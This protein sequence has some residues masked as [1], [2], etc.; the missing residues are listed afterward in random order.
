VDES[1]AAALPD[2]WYID[3]RRFCERRE[4]LSAA[5]G[6]AD[7]PRLDDEAIE[8]FDPIDVKVGALMSPR[9]LQG[10]SVD[11]NGAVSL[12]CQRCLKPFVVEIRRRALFE[13]VDSAGALDAG[14]EDD[15]W[16]RILHAERF[17]LLHLVEDELLLAL[18][19]SARHEACNPV[20]S[21]VVGDRAMPFA[22]LAAMRSAKRR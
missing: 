3:T 5:L 15:E 2:G 13:L 11:L 4:E 17:D 20:D 18:P 12:T 9:G 1:G 16:D 8:A 10:L 22:G 7:L 19:Y 6:P 14:E 21:T